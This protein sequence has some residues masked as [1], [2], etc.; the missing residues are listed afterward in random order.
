MTIPLT[1]A[2]LGIIAAI[3]LWTVT[4]LWKISKVVAAMQQHAEDV[5]RRIA[6]LE[7]RMV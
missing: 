3:L 5:D 1:E 6:L 7:N 2:L 4:E